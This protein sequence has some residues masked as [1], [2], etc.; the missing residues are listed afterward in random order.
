MPLETL[1]GRASLHYYI[2]ESHH[3]MND[4]FGSSSSDFV[5]ATG[6]E[7][8][9]IPQV[10]PGLRAL[11]EYRLTQ[12]DKFWKSDLDLVADSGLRA[13]RWGIPWYQVQPGPDRW[14]WRWIDEVLDYM[15]NMK[16][17]TPVLDLMHYGTPL[18]L[19]NSFINS[20]YPE[21]V[22]QYACEV[23]KRY[24]SLVRYYTP[25]NEPMVN[26]DMCGRNGE[27]PPYLTGDDGYV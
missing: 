17:I 5:W 21:L 2:I 20:R 9:F 11:D 25:L 3:N 7:D 18:W 26:A 15:V 4:L 14:D 24:S 1:S 6:I 13:L 16:G 27:W 12:H 23:T 8:T 22:A 19:E 10:R